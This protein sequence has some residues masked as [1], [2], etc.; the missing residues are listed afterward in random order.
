MINLKNVDKSTVARTLIL[1]VALVNQMLSISG[2]AVIP[3][4]DEQI[5]SLIS[6]V[7]AIGAVVVSWWKNN[8]FTDAAIEADKVKEEIKNGN[9]VKVTDPTSE[10][11]ENSI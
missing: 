2:H 4:E 10:R 6:N 11:R 9:T 7:F 1:I 8:S 3:I 5:E